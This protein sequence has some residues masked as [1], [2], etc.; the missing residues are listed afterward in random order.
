MAVLTEVIFS[1]LKNAKKFAK[2]DLTEAYWQIVR[3][4][5]ARRILFINT[6]KGLYYVNKAIFQRA[7]ETILSDIKGVLIYADDIAHFIGLANYLA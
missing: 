7:M 3:D 2:I 4:E 1:K 5:S 6:R